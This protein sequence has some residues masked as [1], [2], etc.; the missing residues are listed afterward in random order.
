MNL[1][2]MRQFFL[3]SQRYPLWGWA[4]VTG[5]QVI[6]ASDGTVIRLFAL[7]TLLLNY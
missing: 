4:L 3:L 2:D 5:H 1:A 6:T 7:P